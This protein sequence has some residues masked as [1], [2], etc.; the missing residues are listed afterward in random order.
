M[1]RARASSPPIAKSRPSRAGERSK[2]RRGGHD[3][4]DL[5]SPVLRS[6][7]LT[8][9]DRVLY[10]ALG[11]TKAELALY[12]AHVAE[13]MLPHVVRRPLTL[14]RCPQGNEEQCF[15]QKHPGRDAG[16]EIARVPIA[17]KRGTHDYMV[18]EDVEGLLALV[19]MGA[20]EIHTWGSRI[21][22]LEHPDQLVFDIDP[23]E[24]LAWSRVVDAAQLVRTRLAALHLP[25]FL[26]TTGGKGLHVVVPIEPLAEWDEVRRFCKA[27]VETLAKQEPER[28]LTNI[29]KAKRHGK[30]LL[31][32]LRNSRGATAV[33]PYSTRARAQATV[34]TPLAWEE[35]DTKLRPEQL[36]VETVPA[37]IAAQKRDPWADFFEHPGNLAR[38]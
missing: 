5:P 23:D 30:I 28:Y 11:V 3:D 22:R 6:V 32:Y 10:P 13:R 4:I 14:V 17:E 7:S 38:H 18:V 15:F 8:H 37:R 36:T 20:L 16:P 26:K 12:Y 2:S 25:S 9:P 35:L 34:A 31:D 29:S 27:F 21:E 33:A 1:Q 19:Q 24:G